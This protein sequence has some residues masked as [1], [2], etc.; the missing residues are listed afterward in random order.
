M[1]IKAKVRFG[2]LNETKKMKE[3]DQFSTGR[4]QNESYI[5]HSVRRPS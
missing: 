1:W 5:S 3:S 4:L 2:N